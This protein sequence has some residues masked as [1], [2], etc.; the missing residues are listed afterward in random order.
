[1]RTS[2]FDFSP[3]FRTAVGFDRAMRALEN[4]SRVDESS[5][6]Y[7]PYNIEQLD[8]EH[9][10]ITMAVA[11][12]GEDDIEVVLHEG[13]LTVKS[14][15]VSDNGEARKFLHRGIAARAFERRFQ[16]AEHIE[17][18]GA[19]LQNGL[20]HVDLKR[21]VPEELKPR[22]IEIKASGA[23]RIEGKAA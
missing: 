6:A 22:T 20:L 15:A 7:P 19:D 23:K 11:G 13:T 16:L 21:V 2:A 5:L 3:L 12:F 10:R 9:H 8:D 14:K 17:V 18:T 4:A 1:M